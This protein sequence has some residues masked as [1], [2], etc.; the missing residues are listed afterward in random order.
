[1]TTRRSVLLLPLLAA[2]TAWAQPRKTWRIGFLGAASADSP[3][4]K[5][6]V[7]GFRSGLRELGYT[8]G[9]NTV[10][11]FRWAN[12][13]A[14]RLPAL[15]AEL[16][17]ANVDV[18]VT[19]TTQ[20][21]LAA[22]GATKTVPIVLASVGDPVSTGVVMSLARPGVNITGSAMFAADETVK[23][24][25]LLRDALPRTRR[26]VVLIN[27]GNPLWKH[28]VERIAQNAA[29]QKLEVEFLEARSAAQLD[30]A[31]SAIAQKRPD[32]V[33]IVEDSLFTAEAGKLAALA[34]QHRLPS[35]G[36]L[37]FAEAGGLIGNGANQV[38]LFRRAAVFVDK[39][40]RG[41][42]PE[43]LPIEQ[44]S[45]F[46]LVVNLKTAKALGIALP[47]QFLFRVDRQIE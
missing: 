1:M 11:E 17:A 19:A 42:K 28:A 29:S 8:E 22:K 40:L 45:R 43:D 4:W 20:G 32:A 44:A 26:V 39:I 35:I 27:P 25:E 18:L 13:N 5:R 36:H 41:A 2:A 10:I 33:V 12:G 23:R 7:E 6:R 21:A 47:K 30:G 38:E 16:V 15:A 9:K 24:L 46:E 14:E 34:L 31:F 37:P 3:V